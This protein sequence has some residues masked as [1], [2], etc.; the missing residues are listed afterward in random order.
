MAEPVWTGQDD[1]LAG[2]S[3]TQLDRE[4]ARLA[5][6]R[7]DCE[8]SMKEISAEKMRRKDAKAEWLEERLSKLE[9]S[10]E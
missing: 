6:L 10:A 7:D 1:R 5:K 3:V 2:V 4:H 8:T 9:R